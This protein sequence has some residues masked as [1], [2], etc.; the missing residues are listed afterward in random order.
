MGSR[1]SGDRANPFNW[2]NHL[3]QVGALWT[4]LADDNPGTFATSDPVA[5]VADPTVT[6]ASGDYTGQDPITVTVVTAPGATTY[7][8]EGTDVEPPDPDESDEVYTV[9]FEEGP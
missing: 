8:T 7:M 2:G 3:G 5:A 4:T 9:P 6:P 1:P